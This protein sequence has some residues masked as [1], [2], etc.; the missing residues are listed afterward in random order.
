MNFFNERVNSKVVSSGSRCLARLIMTIGI[1]IDRCFCSFLQTSVPTATQRTLPRP[2]TRPARP[3]SVRTAPSRPSYPRMGA[4]DWRPSRRTKT[5]TP[6]ATMPTL[7]VS[8]A[9]L[10]AKSHVPWKMRRKPIESKTQQSTSSGHSISTKSLWRT[11]YCVCPTS[12]LL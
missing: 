4:S 11:L 9:T 10:F 5:S 3:V 7:W 2:L 8:S 1:I 6:I 12:S